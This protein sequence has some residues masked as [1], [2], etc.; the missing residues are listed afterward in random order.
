[1]RFGRIFVVEGSMNTKQYME[2]I[3]TRL[4]PQA[5]QWFS[6]EEWLFQQDN[7]PCHSSKATKDFFNRSNMEVMQWPACSPD[8]SPIET[9]WAVIKGKLRRMSLKSKPDLINALFNICVRDTS[10]Q[11]QLAEICKKLID[12][13]PRR[14]AALLKAKGGHTI[15]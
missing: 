10:D 12:D 1:M 15:F 2:A 8:M 4:L 14:V 3:Q 13:M 6:D 9:I 7:A 5:A 11:E